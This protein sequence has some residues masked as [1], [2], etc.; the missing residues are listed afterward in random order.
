MLA[1][2][3][4]L[5]SSNSFDSKQLNLSADGPLANMGWVE[6]KLLLLPFSPVEHGKGNLLGNKL[7]TEKAGSA[8]LC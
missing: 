5:S 2:R 6:V 3:A 4:R 7:R 8:K 1:F